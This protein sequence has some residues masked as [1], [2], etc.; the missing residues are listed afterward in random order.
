MTPRRTLYFAPETMRQLSGSFRTLALAGILTAALVSAQ[1]A[2][3]PA[4]APA[5]TPTPAVAPE[6]PTPTPAAAPAAPPAAAEPTATPTPR[7]TPLPTATRVPMSAPPM[8]LGDTPVMSNSRLPAE[9]PFGAAVDEPA[10]LPPRPPFADSTIP[11]SLFAAV[12]V[13]ATGKVLAARIVRDPIPSLA[14]EEKR[15]F[16]QRW[17][18]DPALKAGQPVDTWASLRL[19]LQV[20]IHPRE[21][22][23]TLTPVTRA[24]ALPVPF[25][26]GDDARWYEAFKAAPPADGTVLLDVVD[27]T[28]NPKRTKWSADSYKGPFSSRFW[29]KV[30]A[31]GRIEKSIPIQVSDPVLIPYMRRTIS[32]W[33][34]SPA[35]VK[36]QAIDS[37]NELSVSGQLSYSIEIKQI[38][39]LHK[40]LT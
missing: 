3:A 10:A 25:L 20:E 26:W 14:A 4:Q 19:D 24:T 36:G 37:W 23:A 38:N 33:T 7:P 15:S 31:S 34:V 21:E 28:P 5:E 29:V 22:Q 16:E 12:R 2:P 9:N 40:S 17:A 35:R 8:R 1:T 18:F 6:T 32:S 27:T 13:D 39:N 11:A 30:G